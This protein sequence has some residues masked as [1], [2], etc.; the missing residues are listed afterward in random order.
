MN[1]LK[2]NRL[3][4]S[5]AVVAL[6]LWASTAPVT[7]GQVVGDATNRFAQG[8]D[9]GAS[10]ITTT[11]DSQADETAI[12]TTDDSVPSAQCPTTPPAIAEV[13]PPTPV[14]LAAAPGEPGTFHI[15]GTD[16][17]AAAE[18]EQLIGGR[19]FSATLAS[20]GDGCADLTIRPTSLVGSGSS[21]SNL[22]VSLG[23]GR[24]LSIQIVSAQGVTHANITVG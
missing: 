8:A 14:P 6:A 15:C 12:T 22:S 2:S 7:W 24:T 10:S 23:S 1:P 13:T 5:V 18:I 20:H 19:G 4:W 17:T 3:A 9:D 11:M 21:S 16:Q